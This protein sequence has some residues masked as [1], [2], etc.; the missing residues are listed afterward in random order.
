MVDLFELSTWVENRI[1]Q[2]FTLDW[3][4]RAEMRDNQLVLGIKLYALF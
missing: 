1:L 4:E 3:T 2:L